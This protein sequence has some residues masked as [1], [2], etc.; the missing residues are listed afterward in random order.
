MLLRSASPGLIAVN[1]VLC[2]LLG[3]AVLA[4][5]GA[6]LLVVAVIFGFQLL[7]QGILR[8]AA[9]FEFELP[10]M[11]KAAVGLFGVLLVIVG[12]ACLLSPGRSLELLVVFIAVGWL[13]D[14]IAGAAL[15]AHLSGGSRVAAWALAALSLLGAIV[16]FVWPGL[17]LVTLVVV[18]GWLLIFFGV[19]RLFDAMRARRVPVAA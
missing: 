11:L 1:G 17:S 18:A 2:I 7:I 12:I 9:A 8:I 19:G 6:T 3:I 13:F 15:G 5:P 16:L 4:W 14:A 10:G